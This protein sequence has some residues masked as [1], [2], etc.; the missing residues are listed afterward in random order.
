MARV[1]RR[2]VSPALLDR[3]QHPAQVIVTAFA[4]A[5][6]VGTGLLVTPLA[7]E[8]GTATRLIDALFTAVSAVCDRAGNGGHRQPLVGLR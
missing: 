2:S 5:A 8:S 3:F 1:M 7:A 6:A 4:T